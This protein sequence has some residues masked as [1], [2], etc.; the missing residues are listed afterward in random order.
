MEPRMCWNE[1]AGTRASGVQAIMG[2]SSM[3]DMV[4]A[5]TQAVALLDRLLMA[6]QDAGHDIRTDVEL[7]AFAC[8]LITSKMKE[9]SSPLIRDLEE[10]SCFRYP[11]HS[12]RDCELDV[13]VTVSWD[14]HMET[15]LYPS[16]PYYFSSLTFITVKTILTLIYAVI[17]WAAFDLLP[18]NFGIIAPVVDPAILPNTDHIGPLILLSYCRGDH[19]RHSSATIAAAATLSALELQHGATAAAAVHLPISLAAVARACAGDLR[20]TQLQLQQR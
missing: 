20:A 18:I 10:L 6:K 9:S 2:L 3:Y 11:V 1:V 19:L 7:Y 17:S 12:I 15:G 16:H 5:A 8:F 4:E 13:L 14:L